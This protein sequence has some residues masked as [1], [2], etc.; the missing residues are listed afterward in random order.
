[1]DDE[2]KNKLD[3]ELKKHQ[4]DLNSRPIEEFDNLSPAD[5]FNLIYKPFEKESPIQYKEIIPTSILDKIPFLNLVE[6]LLNRISEKEFIKLTPKGNLPTKLVKEL[7]GLGM[8]KEDMIESGISKLYKEEN[9]LSISN[10]KI[11]SIL[12]GLIKK[13]NGKLN[14]TKVGQKALK[15]ENRVDLLKK[16]FYS[17][18]FKFNLGFHDNY[19]DKSG[20]QSCLSYTLFQLLKNGIEVKDI[21]F[22][23]QKMLIAYPHVL[24]EFNSHSYSTP[25]DQFLS[26][27]K[28]RLMT[29]FLNWFNFIEIIH[30]DGQ[31]SSI[32]NF[33]LK[34]NLIS[35]VLEIRNENF[36]F[37]KGKY[38]A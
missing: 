34:S 4:D 23:S 7:Y 12:S 27:Y 10:V 6:Y 29:R 2:L 17:Y 33:S 38:H 1:M 15:P 8:I 36:K 24:S 37:K 22:Y 16:I 13:T 32:D 25:E 28:V 20:V 5:M 19:E 31:K 14:L 11:I 9:S 26:C 35:E 18:A 21:S 30:E 3:E